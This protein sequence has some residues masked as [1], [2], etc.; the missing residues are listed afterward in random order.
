[1]LDDL[2]GMV[3]VFFDNLVVREIAVAGNV[4]VHGISVEMAI[5]DVH[6]CVDLGGRIEMATSG[7]G[8]GVAVGNVVALDNFAIAHGS[9]FSSMQQLE[10]PLKGQF[11]FEKHSCTLA[12][13][14]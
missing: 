13:N 7:T 9:D 10:E 11:G 4:D 5:Y 8:V 6:S 12:Q 1:M 14:W 2:W 3:K